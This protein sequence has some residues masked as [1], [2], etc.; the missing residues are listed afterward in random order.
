MQPRPAIVVEGLSRT[1]AVRR[2]R[3]GVGGALRGLVSRDTREV[4]AVDDVSFTVDAGE[5]VGYVGPNG[6]GKSTTIKMLTGI[7][8]PTA[9][10]AIVAGL[11]PWRQ[12][13]ELASRIGVVFGQ[14]TQLWWDLPLVESLGLLRHI[15]RVPSGRFAE[16]LAI[17]HRDDGI[18]VSILCPQAVDTPMLAGLPEGPQ[19]IDGVMSAP[20]VVRIALAGWKRMRS[21]PPARAG[22]GLSAPESRRL[23]PLAPQHGEVA[24]AVCIGPA[25]WRLTFFE[26]L[27]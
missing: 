16:N 22:G 7:L 21:H 8:V 24:E 3:P 18:R 1:F 4:R 15:Y 12:R 27:F 17:T 20:D 6:A 13:R 2:R 11:V 10:E 23:R 26:I 25:H 14:R 5:I 9:G 19:S